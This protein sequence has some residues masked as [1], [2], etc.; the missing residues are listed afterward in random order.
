MRGCFFSSSFAYVDEAHDIKDVTTQSPGPLISE[1]PWSEP[2]MFPVQNFLAG[3][4]RNSSSSPS[5]PL[6]DS[7]GLQATSLPPFFCFRGCRAFF[8]RLELLFD[9]SRFDRSRYKKSGRIFSSVDGVPED[10]RLWTWW[11]SSSPPTLRPSLRPQTGRSRTDGANMLRTMPCY[12]SK[13]GGRV[14]GGW[15][16]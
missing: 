12:P 13:D 6:R 5:R 15:T 14:L 4:I 1:T 10:S 16:R 2:P 8:S 9:R 11:G 7:T 3:Y